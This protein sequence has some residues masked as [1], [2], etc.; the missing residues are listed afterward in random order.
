V[1]SPFQSGSGGFT[2]GTNFSIIAGSELDPAV[3]QKRRLD[4]L[5]AA[6]ADARSR[7]ITDNQINRILEGAGIGGA[8]V[9]GNIGAGSGLAGVT[10]VSPGTTGADAIGVAIGLLGNALG[11]PG[12]SA[13]GNS[14][15]GLI[16]SGTSSSANMQNSNTAMNSDLGGPGGGGSGGNGAGGGDA[17]AGPAGAAGGGVR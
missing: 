13:L 7:G 9:G 14:V 11:V 1:S 17:G 5:E 16:G 10:G 3:I 12:A 4:A 8:D 6:K 2:E 15:S